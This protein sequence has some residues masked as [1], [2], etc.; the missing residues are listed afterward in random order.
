M[1]RCGGYAWALSGVRACVVVGLDWRDGHVPPLPRSYRDLCDFMQACEGRAAM[2]SF[3]DIDA[4]ATCLMPDPEACC[5]AAVILP[6]AWLWRRALGSGRSKLLHQMR[7]RHV[8]MAR[9]QLQL[10]T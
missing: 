1:L 4:V 2:P 5:V 9:H 10:P 6:Y 8:V 3:D 7:P